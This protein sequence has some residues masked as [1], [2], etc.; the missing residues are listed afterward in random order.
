M[1][2]LLV[3]YSAL[4]VQSAVALGALEKPAYGCIE[5]GDADNLDG[6]VDRALARSIAAHD[7]PEGMKNLEW[8]VRVAYAQIGSQIAFSGEERRAMVLPG[9]KALPICER[10]P[11]PG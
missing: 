3:L 11:L 9:L 8:Q 2:G 4:H 1:I 10:P 7:L 6:L 5:P